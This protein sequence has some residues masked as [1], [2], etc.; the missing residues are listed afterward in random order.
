MPRARVL[1]TAAALLGVILVAAGVWAWP[2]PRFAATTGPHPV[3][4]TTL[5]WTDASRP[6]I[7]GCALRGVDRP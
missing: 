5:A 1:M 6:E 3:G 2:R 7:T 4:T